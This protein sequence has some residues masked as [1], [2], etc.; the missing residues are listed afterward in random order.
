MKMCFSGF[1]WTTWPLIKTHVRVTCWTSVTSHNCLLAI[2][3]RS[4]TIREPWNIPA[5]IHQMLS[6]TVLLA[7]SESCMQMAKRCERC[8]AV[9]A[10][11]DVLT[12]CVFAG[13]R[14]SGCQCCGSSWFRLCNH[15][16]RYGY[17]MDDTAMLWLLP[18]FGIRFNIYLQHLQA[19]QNYNTWL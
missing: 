7:L 13:K 11:P 18:F 9:H 1:L 15:P 5:S 4:S 14:R 12:S 17:C 6:R 2:S 19:N 10:G 16:L 3:C 8:W